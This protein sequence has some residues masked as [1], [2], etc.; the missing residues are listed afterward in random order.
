MNPSHQ[1]TATRII[2][3][4]SCMIQLWFSV[5]SWQQVVMKRGFQAHDGLLLVVGGGA[6]ALLLS[7]WFL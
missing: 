5:S 2:V 6:A 4:A 7:I 1:D 3:T